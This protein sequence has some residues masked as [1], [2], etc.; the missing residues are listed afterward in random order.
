MTM[1][2]LLIAN[3]KSHKNTAEIT[4]WFQTLSSSPVPNDI[5]LVVA[6]SFVHLPRVSDLLSPKSRIQL[7]SQDVSPFPQGSYTGAVAASQLADLGVTYCL[8]GHSERREYFHESAVEV[9]N[10]VRELLAVSLTPVVCLRSGDLTSQF[11]ALSGVDL[12]RLIFAYEP[13]EHIGTG[14]AA[15]VDELMP[16][17][18][19]LRTLAP[20]SKL[21]YGGSVEAHNL[22]TFAPLE[23]AGFLVGSASLDPARFLTLIEAFRG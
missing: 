14:T 13:V 10:K 1:T 5:E 11:A 21:L 18:Q 4:T 9:A 2:P 6:P 19:E 22:A 20:E 16:V 15:T 3:F 12:T 23:L 8:V 7:C 17:Y